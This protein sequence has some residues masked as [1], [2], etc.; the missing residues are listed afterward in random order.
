MTLAERTRLVERFAALEVERHQLLGTLAQHGAKQLEHIPGPGQWSAA[1][2]IV[3][4]AVVEEGLLAYLRK[5]VQYGGHGPVSANAPF[6]LALLKLALRSP[7]KF[8][9]PAVVAH[10]PQVSMA[11]AQDRWEH[12]RA[13]LYEAIGSLPDE[14]LGH[15]LIKHPTAGRFTPRQGLSFIS[16]HIGHHK[17]Q[18]A[19]ILRNAK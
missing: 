10:A 4:F 14:A 6:R 19:R 7:L 9:A 3:H 18:L 1:Q 12:A 16:A 17:R 13:A 15:G 8:K 11:E 5:K 2:V